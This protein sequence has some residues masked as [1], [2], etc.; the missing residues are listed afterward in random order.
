MNTTNIDT[1]TYN[2]TDLRFRLGAILDELDRRSAPI[3]IIS[4]SKP[5]AWLYPYTK[6]A[7]TS[8]AFDK[9]QK[10]ALPKYKKIK[11]QKMIEL[12]RID[13]DRK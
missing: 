7:L 1:T 3:L 12:I 4:R 2:A 6:K 11:A 5:C 8:A 9:W 10:E 13:R